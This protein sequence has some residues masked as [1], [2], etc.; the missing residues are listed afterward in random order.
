VD[1]NNNQVPPVAPNPAPAPSQQPP[2]Q[3]PNFPPVTGG[4]PP[5]APAP[6]SPQPHK[7]LSGLPFPVLMGVAIVALL[8]VVAL[9][10]F[11][12]F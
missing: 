5:V 10:W 9:S 4:T 11:V 7:G 2:Q 1:P 6:E 3:Q 12:F 8:L